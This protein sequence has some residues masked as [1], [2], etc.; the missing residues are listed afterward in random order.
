MARCIDPKPEARR[1]ASGPLIAGAVAFAVAFVTSGGGPAA[2]EGPAVIEIPAE[3][4]MVKYIRH[5]N[6]PAEIEGKLLELPVEEG[7]SVARGDVL[8]V[9]DDTHAQLTLNLSKA[10]EKEASLNAS[11]DVNLRDATNAEKLALAEAE[12]YRELYRKG[13]VPLYEMRKKELEAVRATLRIELA[14]NEMSVREA[15]Y[16]ASRSEREIAEFEVARR[17][18]TA[19]FDGFVEMRIAQ[20]GEWVQPGS[21]IV[22]VVQLDRLRVEGDVDALLYARQIT[23]GMPALVKVYTGGGSAEAVELEGVV[24]F[25]SSEID[26]NNH[27]R[28]WVDVDNYREGEDWVLKPGMRAEIMLRRDGATF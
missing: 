16:I 11:S 28:L 4:C 5:V 21:P 18:V 24:G 14:E 15:Q 27:C 12:S 23:A 25:V 3:R 10:K 17:R 2:A 7:T 8:A 1:S 20:L 26:L 13:A 22:T 19:P 9:V 6:I